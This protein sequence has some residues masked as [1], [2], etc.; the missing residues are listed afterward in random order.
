MVNVG[1]AL[2]CALATLLVTAMI[3]DAR[4][5]RIPNWLNGGIALI[6]PA[7]WV[8]HA[9]PLWPDIAIQFGIALGM[10]ALLSILMQAGQMGGGDVKMIAA[11]ALVFSPGDFVLMLIGMAAI[12][13]IMTAGVLVHHR[14]RTPD[15]PF[16]NPYGI[17]IA[18]GALLVLGEWY[19]LIPT[20]DILRVV[21]L[22][23][24]MLSACAL[25]FVTVLRIR[26]RSEARR[27]IS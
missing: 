17:A 1:I 18:L 12:G 8:V 22:V 25:A 26:R 21:F 4:E 16:E 5:R 13:G 20:I 10:L 23:S 3:T 24:V 2:S 27:T 7:L 19:Q 11:L 15:A 9:V 14:L 6:A